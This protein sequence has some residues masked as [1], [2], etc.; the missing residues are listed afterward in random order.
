M[1]WIRDLSYMKHN[2]AHMSA[3]KHTACFTLLINSFDDSP[4]FFLSQNSQ[5]SFFFTHFLQAG[6]SD[7]GNKQFSPSKIKQWAMDD[8]T[9]TVSWLE[10]QE[11]KVGMPS[12]KKRIYLCC[13]SL[14]A[15]LRFVLIYNKSKACLADW[16]FL[17]LASFLIARAKWTE[18]NCCWRSYYLSARCHRIPWARQ[19]KQCNI[20]LF[21]HKRCIC[22][23]CL[24]LIIKHCASYEWFTLEYA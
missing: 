5:S 16:L 11:E 15:G 14:S 20:S 23:N 4:A 2:E 22:I 7:S 24:L 1:P 12:G 9:Q 8:L 17:S 3:C 6:H 18:G 21:I 10:S 13:I 19:C